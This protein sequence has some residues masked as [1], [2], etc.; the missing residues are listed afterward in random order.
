LETTTTGSLTL[1]GGII[2]T[3]SNTVS[4]LNPASGAVSG[5]EAYSIVTPGIYADNGYVNGNVARQLSGAGTYDFPLGEGTGGNGYNRIVLDVTSGSGLV[6]VSYA[7]G[8]PGSINVATTTTCGPT[9]YDVVYNAMNDGYWTFSQTGGTTITYDI[10]AYPN[11]VAGIS[12]PS[13]DNQYRVLKAPTG[14]SDWSPYALDGDPC[15]V[16]TG[17]YEVVGSGYSG[18]SD[19]GIGGGGTPLPVTLVSLDAVSMADQVLVS[20]ATA[21]ELNSD[22]Y[23]VERSASGFAWTELGIVAAA[24]T[25][26][27]AHDYSFLDEAPLN[28]VSYYRLRQ[29]DQDGTMEHSPAVAVTR[30]SAVQVISVWPN[31]TSGFVNLVGLQGEVI[32][33]VLDLMGR[34]VASF[35]PGRLD[36]GAATGTY[37]FNVAAFPAGSYWLRVL[38]A[39]GVRTVLLNKQ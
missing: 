7:P 39:N 22:F 18:F 12:A 19:F 1:T 14:T 35:A 37:R 13:A 28:G 30:S 6:E 17:F 38:D 11:Q 21:T 34:S 15:S 33:E 5:F 36:M 26:T 2:E 29:V 16:S 31:P 27:E 3:G 23:A 10:T 32:V 8:S 20:W 9:T 25:T 24:G 4:I